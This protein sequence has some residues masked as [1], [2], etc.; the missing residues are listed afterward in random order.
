[1]KHMYSIFLIWLWVGL[2]NMGC[3]KQEVHP[4]TTPNSSTNIN[5]LEVMWKK[6]L[7]PDTTNGKSSMPPIVIGNKVIFS[8]AN[9]NPSAEILDAYDTKTG[10]KL[11][12]WSN[13]INP[14]GTF[15]DI[16]VSGDKIIVCTWYEV[17]VIDSN[18]G[19]T[20]WVTQR[21]HGQ[22]RIAVIG[23]YIYHTFGTM[24]T[25]DTVCYLIRSPI[26]HPQWDTIYTAR[27]KN[28]F[29]PGIES[30]AL[31]ISP[32]GDSVLIFQN[33][34]CN[35][36]TRINQID[37]IAYSLTQKKEIFTILNIDKDRGSSVA[38]ITVYQNKIYF[39]GIGTVYCIDPVAG[40]VVW[41]K[42]FTGFGENFAGN[43]LH[44][45][46]NRL[47]VKPW[48]Q[49]IYSLDPASGSV[50]WTTGNVTSGEA[51]VVCQNGT[52][53]FVSGALNAVDFASGKLLWT[54][55]SPNQYSPN[56]YYG[57]FDVG[58]GLAFDPGTSY[59]FTADDR[60][61]M[62]IKLPN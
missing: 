60:W 21:P 7:A 27:M 50:I 58:D 57:V 51:S 35:F 23:N 36:T 3:K 47:I 38:P 42:V 29:S 1:M 46:N 20:V 31:W 48:G 33:R 28:G 18:T 32:T 12:E 56:R 53:Y 40:V 37:L 9:Y 52:I 61:A 10:V 14:A 26:D 45:I 25:A 54:K 13:Y 24:K 22:P 30:T 19:Q 11:W 15:S 49:S 8:T 55:N 17:Y 62:S 39:L 16:K 43:D 34:Q 41:N 2:F 6:P 44:V 59:L 4:G 5:L